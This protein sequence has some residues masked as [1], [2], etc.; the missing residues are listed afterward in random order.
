MSLQIPTLSATLNVPIPALVS[1][2]P[3]AQVEQTKRFVI[4]H[5]VDLKESDVDVFRAFGQVVTYDFKVEAHIPI[6]NLQ[7]DYLFLDLR[8]KQSR[9]YYDLADLQE[10]NV[11]GY[12]SFI[13]KF[14]SYVDS[15]GCANTLTS[16]PPRTHYKSSY[17]L[18]LLQSSTD[19]PNKCLSIINFAG[20]FLGSLK[21]TTL[22]LTQ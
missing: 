11:I 20:S 22:A 18:A 6:D 8:N 14:D 16:F 13:E 21:K 2:S 7:F 5:T 15:L 12:I 1:L 19:S 10:Y 9:Q 4:I 3:V 17:D